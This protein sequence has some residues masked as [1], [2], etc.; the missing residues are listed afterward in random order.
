MNTDTNSKYQAD[1][2]V[3]GSGGG[4]AAAVTAA[5]AGAKIILLDKLE[6]LGGYTRQANGLMACESP[7]QKRQNINVTK[8]KTS[9]KWGT[10]PVP[11][12]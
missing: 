10:T 6:R 3:I 2:V 11:A 7:A 4:L 12:G 9:D 1:I 8:D 5:E